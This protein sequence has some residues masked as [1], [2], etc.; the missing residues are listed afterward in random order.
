MARS[1]SAQ[2][3]RGSR[4]T[5]ARTRQDARS[6]RRAKARRGAQSRRD[7][8]VRKSSAR[9]AGGSRRAGGLPPAR[10]G[11]P[12]QRHRWI[13]AAVLVCALLLSGRL[14]WVQ[15]L[16]AQAL[17]AQAVKDRT[18][19]RTIAA[20]RGEILDDTGAVLASSVERYDLWVNQLQVGDYRDGAD[21]LPADQ[22]G[23]KGAAQQ[24]APLLGWSVEKTEKA[25]TG[26]RGFVYLRKQVDPEVRDAV[27]S[28]GIDGIGSDRVSRRIYPA[29][30]VGGNVIGFTGSDG[31]ALAGAELQYDDL[32]RGQNGSVT[33]ERGAGGQVIPTG[34]QETVEA[35]DGQDI[36]L[37]IDRDVQWRAQQIVQQTVE[38]WGTAGGS[39][40][41]LDARTGQIVALADYPTFDPN[42]PGQAA[43]EHRGNM[44]ISDVFEP[45][46]TGK[47]ITVAAAL[48]EGTV[49]PS[50]QYTVPYTMKIN[51]SEIKDASPHP[52][53]HLTVAGVLRHSSNIGAVQIAETM[54]PETRHDYMMRFGLGKP[55]GVGLPGESGGIVHPASA[56]Q[57]HTRSAIAF[58]HGYSVTALQMTTVLGTLVNDGVRVQPSIVAGTRG[59]D[60]EIT[61][62]SQPEQTR[63]VSS[64]TAHTMIQ[65]LDNAADD[66]TSGV[67]VP[68]YATAGKSGTAQVP[69]GTY[70]TSFI[71]TAPADDPR[72]VVG[73]FLFGMHGF[74]S[75]TKSAGPAFSELMSATLQDRGVAP[76]GRPQ[77]TFEN[78]W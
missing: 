44:A 13:L 38:K 59:P 42:A 27:M 10:V 22:K 63:V 5:G 28:L 67:A 56:W 9:G 51:G 48:E 47:M 68:H 11:T 49:S 4:P 69:D 26:D 61:P 40:V 18:A 8:Q 23:I 45:G 65:L 6:S 74:N 39:A 66:E 16:N 37:T 60:G 41:V 15:G 21:D 30:S 20:P 57:G 54:T 46:S 72:Y 76:T 7:P 36:Q 43:P 58:G 24:L 25:L 17:A 35:V 2:R 71:G 33:Y 50:T 1:T 34:R 64:E 52:V 29:G 75:G 55:T 77:T 32:L 31:T 53:E 3:P 78:E 73:V 70:T 12:R 14:L 19:T 62:L